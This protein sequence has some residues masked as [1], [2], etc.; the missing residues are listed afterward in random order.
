MPTLAV[1]PVTA[2]DASG[3]EPERWLVFLHGILGSGANWRTFARQITAAKP[4]LGALL[5]DLR[6]HGESRGLPPP[7]TVAAAARDVVEACAGK[8]VT[9]VLGHSFGGKVA[10][11]C[12]RTLALEHLFVVDSTPGAR[13]DY[14]GSSNVRSVVEL[15]RELPEHF[16]DRNAF[17]QWAVDRGVSRPTAMWLAMNVRA[18]DQGRFV[19]RVDVPSIRVMM[20]DYFKVDLW[21]V[22]EDG[23]QTTHLIAG[24][25]SEVL[26]AA[27]LD[28]AR[29]LPRCTVDVIPDAGHWVHVDAP[30]A[31]REMVLGYLG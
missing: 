10:I 22:I 18:D 26:D 14:R 29:A 12:A 2:P 28:R 6:L 24:G 17:T 23:A 31:L 21:D 1:H 13:P 3:R 25:K 11:E 4:E 15:L 27:D 5:V 19:F 20:E 7:H 16:P 9:A 30:D 8:R